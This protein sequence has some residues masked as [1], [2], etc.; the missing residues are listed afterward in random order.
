MGGKNGRVGEKAKYL[1]GVNP[2]RNLKLGYS[3][4]LSGATHK[5]IKSVNDI[6]EGD[7]LINRVYQ[8][9]FTSSVDRITKSNKQ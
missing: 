5:V 4:I 6:S 9:W 7:S 3:I 1:A 8:G 2:E